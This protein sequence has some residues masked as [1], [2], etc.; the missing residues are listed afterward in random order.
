MG[1]K[2]RKCVHFESLK[3]GGDSDEFIE[4]YDRALKP[5]KQTNISCTLMPL[6]HDL[7]MKPSTLGSACPLTKV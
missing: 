3:K 6:L 7:T 5:C 4:F 1:I 2:K